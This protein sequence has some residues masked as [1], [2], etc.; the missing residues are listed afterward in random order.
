MHLAQ[1]HDRAQAHPIEILL[2]LPSDSNKLSSTVLLCQATSSCS[3]ATAQTY[4]VGLILTHTTLESRSVLSDNRKSHTGVFPILD[5]KLPSRCSL[6]ACAHYHA[7]RCSKPL[8]R[9]CCLYKVLSVGTANRITCDC[10]YAAEPLQ[11]RATCGLFSLHLDCCKLS[12]KINFLKRTLL[13]AFDWSPV[14]M[15]RAGMN[16]MIFL[17]N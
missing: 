10:L 4:V 6:Y 12:I 14:L 16:S 13:S 9:R 1:T 3:P 2:P 7:Q 5:E 11:I 8:V 17:F 15:R